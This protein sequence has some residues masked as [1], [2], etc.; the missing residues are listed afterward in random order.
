MKR[1][2]VLALAGGVV[3]A[4][5]CLGQENTG[6]GGPPETESESDGVPDSDGDA[7]CGKTAVPRTLSQHDPHPEYDKTTVTVL[8][9]AGAERDSV[10]AAIADTSS[11]RYTGLSDTESLPFDRGML[12][13]YNSGGERTYVMRDMDF[14]LDI[15]FVDENREITTIHHAPEPGPDENGENQTYSGYG[16][17]V[18]EVNIDWTTANC[19]VEGDVLEFE[20]PDD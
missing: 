16:Q 1:R 4:A 8:T 2:R 7:A 14:G 15:I 5:G 12:F 6:P 10:T 13:V 11:L 18:L 9:P 19:V 20:L 3:A 17:Y